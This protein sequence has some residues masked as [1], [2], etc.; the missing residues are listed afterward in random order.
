MKRKICI[1][2]CILFI[3]LLPVA[4][5]AENYFYSDSWATLEFK[6]VYSTSNRVTYSTRYSV[7]QAYCY[8]TVRYHG[9]F[10]SDDGFQ[11]AYVSKATTIDNNHKHEYSSS[12][13]PY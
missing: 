12:T 13:K 2:F 10:V 5:K 6:D 1:V 4:T 11:N 7:R 8:V 3:M 9:L